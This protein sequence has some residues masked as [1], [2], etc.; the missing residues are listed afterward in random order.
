MSEP[1]LALDSLIDATESSSQKIDEAHYFTVTDLTQSLDYAIDPTANGTAPPIITCT[2]G[3]TPIYTGTPNVGEFL[4]NLRASTITLNP[5][6]PGLPGTFHFTYWGFG[7]PNNA[8][9]LGQTHEPLQDTYG[10]AMRCYVSLNEADATKV[11]V[12]EGNFSI[13]GVP[14]TYGGGTYDVDANVPIPGGKWTQVEIWLQTNGTLTCTYSDPA[15]SKGATTSPPVLTD[16]APLARIYFHKGASIVETDIEPHASTAYGGSGGNP[17][18]SV[19]YECDSSVRTGASVCMPDPGT[20]L[21]EANASED[22]QM[23]VFG[24]CSTKPTDTTC[25][26][27]R[28]GPFDF[29]DKTVNAYSFNTSARGT[30]YQARSDGT[31]QEGTEGL[32]V[33]GGWLQ[34]LGRVI[35]EKMIYVE[36]GNATRYKAGEGDG[37]DGDGDGDGD[38]GGKDVVFYYDPAEDIQ[39]GDYVYPDASLY[40]HKAQTSIGPDNADGSKCAKYVVTALDTTNNQCTCRNQF[41][42]HSDDYDGETPGHCGTAGVEY[43]QWYY[44]STETN[45]EATEIGIAKPDNWVQKLHQLKNSAEPSFYIDIKD[46]TLPDPTPP[47][48]DYDCDS[49]VRVGDAVYLDGGKAYR[50]DPTDDDKCNPV[51]IVTAVDNE[52]SPTRCSIAGNGEKTDKAVLAYPGDNYLWPHNTP[53]TYRSNVVWTPGVWQVKIGTVI[54]ASTYTPGFMIVDIQ[55]K[56]KIVDPDEGGGGIETPGGDDGEIGTGIAYY[57]STSAIAAGKAVEKIS[58]LYVSVAK[59]ST[60]NPLRGISLGSTH[61]TENGYSYYRVK[62]RF[63]GVYDPDGSYEEAAYYYISDDNGSYSPIQSPGYYCKQIGIG[64]VDGK[65]LYVAIGPVGPRSVLWTPYAG[66][67][68]PVLDWANTGDNPEVNRHNIDHHDGTTSGSRITLAY[69]STTE[70]P[71]FGETVVASYDVGL[72]NS[73]VAA[74]GTPYIEFDLVDEAGTSLLSTTG[75]IPPASGA[76][77]DT[78]PDSSN[79]TGTTR[80]VIDSSKLPLAAGK[81]I[82]VKYTINTTGGTYLGGSEPYGAWFRLVTYQVKE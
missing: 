30:V 24:F 62:V 37:D 25:T 54:P 2:E 41:T 48:Y 27:V 14:V 81:T 80:P 52:S 29:S 9:F 71:C 6:E 61:V 26:V 21:V 43:D 58:A 65:G 19:T 50:T 39:V 70:W 11:D 51:G 15:D 42:W 57:R 67:P 5:A 10:A 1:T 35:G 32:K 56:G 68:T 28:S 53:G 7:T 72:E 38:G 8:H 23:P 75:K 49:S 82:R 73:G 34:S 4:C 46:P 31:I 47:P 45:G 17:D 78:L 60:K 13:G 16:A 3:L 59:R 63:S 40:V 74:S 76:R 69:T 33:D 77:R 66:D 55:N 22:N 20:P 12:K 36:I 18:E 79:N 44:L 64:W